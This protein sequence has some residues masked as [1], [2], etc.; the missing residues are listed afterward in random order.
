[1]KIEVSLSLKPQ[2]YV[3]ALSGTLFM[4]GMLTASAQAKYLG[5]I[6]QSS[7]PLKFATYWNQVTPENSGKWGSVEQNRDRYSWNNLDQAYN[8]A[9]SNGYPFKQH[10]FVWGNQAPNWIGS[11]SQADQ[12]AEVEEFISDYCQRYPSTNQIDV[13]NEPISAPPSFRNALGGSGATGWDWVIT[14]FEMARLHCPQ[15]ELLINEYG[16][17]ND[18]AKRSRYVEIINILKNRDLVDGIGI[19]SH[20]FNLIGY[21]ASTLKSNLD[22]LAQTGLP[23]YVSEWDIDADDQQQLN[24]YQQK[25]PTVWN[26][27]AVKGVTLWGYIYGT[28]WRQRTGLLYDNGT[29]R[30]ALTWLKNFVSNNN[31]GDDNDDGSDNG[32]TNVFVVRAQGTEGGESISLRIN[33]ES[34]ATWTLTS[35]MQSYTTSSN[36]SGSISIAFTNDNGDRDVRIDHI[37]VNGS[38][39]EAE[40]Q[41][42]NTGVW[43]DGR[44]GGG[45]YSEWLHCDGEINFGNVD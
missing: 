27:P 34:V 44:C 2:K 33:N 42:T 13:V 4:A 21:S 37:Q 17:I 40:D 6:Y 12:R 39:R 8:F 38:I 1:M 23:I 3:I 35:S 18:S 32:N 45:A 31:P 19:Q 16:I 5:N 11:L 24:E 29:E 10:T 26:H 15:A 30:P 14:S 7:T 41:S 20:S 36:R 22:A 28:T 9:I 43:G 25:F